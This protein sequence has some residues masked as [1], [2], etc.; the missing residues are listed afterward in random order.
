MDQDAIVKCEVHW[1]T[2]IFPVIAFVGF[3]LLSTF[4]FVLQNRPAGGFLLVFATLFGLFSLSCLYRV[5]LT[6]TNSQVIGKDGLLKS[7]KSVSPI[8]QIQTVSIKKT[9][10]GKLL[11]YAHICIATAAT[12]GVEYVYKYI[13]NADVFQEAL[14]ELQAGINNSMGGD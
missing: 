4:E 1:I 5:P 11:G 8:W 14:A 7:T 2:W 3:M 6:L 10:P 9:L 12:G 13:K